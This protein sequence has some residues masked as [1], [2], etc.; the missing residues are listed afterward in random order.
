[1]QRGWDGRGRHR[2]HID[3]M[4]ELLQSLLVADAEALLLIDHQ[5]AEVLEFQVLRKQ[6]MSADQDVDLSGF[7]LFQDNLLLLWGAEARDH[8]DRDGELRKT[9]TEG[10]AVL[11]GEAW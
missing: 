2:E 7:E 10:F 11:H 9:V 4:A 8:L 3:L 6:T 5:Q 1:M